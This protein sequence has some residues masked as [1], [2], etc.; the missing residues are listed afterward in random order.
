M[1]RWLR[2]LFKTKTVY[3]RPVPVFSGIDFKDR[4][5]R[6]HHFK[7]RT[8]RSVWVVGHMKVSE[9]LDYNIINIE[10]GQDPR[11]AEINKTI[12]VG[13]KEPVRIEMF[14][15]AAIVIDGGHRITAAIEYYLN[16]KRDIFVQYMLKIHET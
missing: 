9:F 16:T 4:V 15:E 6:E 10:R 3:D 11:L 13:V 1:F 12:S 14:R 8:R 5:L 7:Y 2:S